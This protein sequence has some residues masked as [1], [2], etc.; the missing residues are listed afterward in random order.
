MF[1]GIRIWQKITVGFSIPIFLMVVITVIAYTQNARVAKLVENAEVVMGNS[2]AQDMMQRIIDI[3]QA[4]EK[5]GAYGLQGGTG[6][7]KDVSDQ[8][9][10][11]SVMVARL[12]QGRLSSAQRGKRDEIQAAADGFRLDYLAY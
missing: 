6:N 5:E 3:L 4:R 8:V 1:R 10:A 12:R 9:K 2:G 7:L 11:I